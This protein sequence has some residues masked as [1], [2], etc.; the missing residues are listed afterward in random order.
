MPD[1]DI[2]ILE[3]DLHDNRLTHRHLQARRLSPAQLT[4]YLEA[5]PDLAEEGEEFIVHLGAEPPDE[6]PEI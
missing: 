5:L 2:R 6:E 3:C 1:H 4:A